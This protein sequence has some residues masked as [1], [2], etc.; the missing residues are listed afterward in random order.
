MSRK[1][2][3]RT[4]GNSRG[5]ISRLMSP[6]DLG[7]QL[8]PFIFLDRFNIDFHKREATTLYPHSGIGIVTVFTDG[9]VCFDDSNGVEGTLKSGG[10]EWINSGKGLLHGKAISAGQSKQVQGFQLWLALPPELEVSKARTQF[11]QTDHNQNIGPARVLVGEYKKIKSMVPNTLNINLLMVTLA[12]GQSWTYQPPPKHDVLWL[13]LAKGELL[14]SDKDKSI[15]KSGEMVAYEQGSESV[16]FI[17]NELEPTVFI[18][19]SAVKHP[20]HLCLGRHSVHTSQSALFKGEKH[21]DYLKDL[22]NIPVYRPAK[23]R[24]LPVFHG[25][26]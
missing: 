16:T 15:I 8:K 6:T 22:M 20:Y 9:D 4:Y 5:P 12:A 11:V 17:A 24:D 21:L 7:E 10:L 25:Y 26:S 19:G 18:M 3:S 14:A 13:S 2:S 23:P 1:I